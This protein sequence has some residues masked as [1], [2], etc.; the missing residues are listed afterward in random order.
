M[1]AAATKFQSQTNGCPNSLGQY[2]A[3]GALQQWLSGDREHA[4]AIYANLAR[5]RDVVVE[6]L[7][8]CEGVRLVVPTTTFYAF[9][10][11]GSYYGKRTPGGELIANA[12][13]LCGQLLC[14]ANVCV[15]PGDA[16]GCANNIRIAFVVDGE[17][18]Q[19]AMADI[20]RF[21]NE[22]V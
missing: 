8:Q 6:A 4:N 3:L 20:V 12:T 16:F 2:A 15:V 22:L 5:R 7:G 18:L 14:C 9:P 17:K 13:D 11:V 10:D 21:F 1:I 19:K